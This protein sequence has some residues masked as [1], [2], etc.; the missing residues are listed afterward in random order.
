[1]GLPRVARVLPEVAMRLLRVA[2]VLL[3]WAVLPWDKMFAVMGRL[4]AGQ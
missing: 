4:K 2:E 3:G 1:M